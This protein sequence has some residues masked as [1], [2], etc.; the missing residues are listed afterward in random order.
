MKKLNSDQRWMPYEDWWVE[1]E[2]MKY[3]E[4]LMGLPL[5]IKTF[6]KRPDKNCC[7]EY[8]EK[9]ASEYETNFEKNGQF[10]RDWLKIHNNI[11][12]AQ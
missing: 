11:N 3:R 4:F 7:I 6:G 8:L 5:S 9:V 12:F 1:K 10:I 2:Y